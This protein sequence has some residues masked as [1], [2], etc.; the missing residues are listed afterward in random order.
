MILSTRTKTCC[1]VSTSFSYLNRYAPILKHE[2]FSEEREWA[3]RDPTA[4]VSQRT[5]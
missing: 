2:A 3:N 1:A 5:V 4:N